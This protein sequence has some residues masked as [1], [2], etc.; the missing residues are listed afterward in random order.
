VLDADPTWALLASRSIAEYASLERRSGKR[1]HHPVGVLWSASTPEPLAQL[2]AVGVGFDTVV[3]EPGLGG[4]DGILAVDPEFTLLER[5]MAGFIEPR[6]M[7]AAQCDLADCAGAEFV[8]DVASSVERR[9]GRWVV[10]L[11][12]GDSLLADCVIIAAGAASGALVDVDL[13]VTAEVVMDVTLDPAGRQ[14]DGLSCLG[15]FNSHGDVD[16]YFTPPV[17]TESGW[18]LKLGS[19]RSDPV[20]LTNGD[21]VRDWMCGSEHTARASEML[22]ALGELLPDLAVSQARTR[23]C[24]YAR[25][26]TGLPSV[27]ELDAG[28]FVATG[29]NG[30]MAK[31][32]D[33]VAALAVTLAIDGT[34]D[35]QFPRER[36]RVANIG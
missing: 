3:V 26:P 8:R 20:A 14:F 17:A 4:W 10:S 7:L 1:F 2:A 19:E 22:A 28:L 11:R 23:P 29:G 9:N 27:D 15:R 5:G 25:T 30:R 12:G 35:D 33:A 13:T 16:A 6:T 18:V 24:I 32:A 36:F 21:D 34:W 31:S